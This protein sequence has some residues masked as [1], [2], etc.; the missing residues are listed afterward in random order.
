MHS[1]ELLLPCPRQGLGPC[2]LWVRTGRSQCQTAHLVQDAVFGP[3]DGRV[4]HIDPRLLFFGAHSQEDEIGC[5]REMEASSASKG[6]AYSSRLAR[7]FINPVQDNACSF[8]LEEETVASSQLLF[9]DPPASA[10][11]AISRGAGTCSARGQQEPG[12][13]KASATFISTGCRHK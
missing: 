1:S 7:S 8:V 6:E 9:Y 5:L 3:D 4:E 12:R 10:Y 2:S 11:P 13:S